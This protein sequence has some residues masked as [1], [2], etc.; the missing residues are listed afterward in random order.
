M[1]G[2]LRQEILISPF[3]IIHRIEQIFHIVAHH[4]EGNL[5]G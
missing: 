2:T 4:P 3:R 5:N 1:V